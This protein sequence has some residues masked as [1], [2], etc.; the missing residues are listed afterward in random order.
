MYGTEQTS[1]WAKCQFTVTLCLQRKNLWGDQRLTTTS[2]TLCFSGVL[3]WNK[4]WKYIYIYS[5]AALLIYSD[6]KDFKTSSGFRIHMLW[7]DWTVRSLHTAAAIQAAGPPTVL[8]EPSIKARATFI[9]PQ[10]RQL[11]AARQHQTWC[12]FIRL[13]SCKADCLGEGGLQKMG[14]QATSWRR[15]FLLVIADIQVGSAKRKL[16]H[17]LHCWEIPRYEEWENWVTQPVLHITECVFI[18]FA[19]CIFF[20]LLP[21]ALV[22]IIRSS[23]INIPTNSLE[24]EP[25]SI[26]LYGSQQRGEGGVL[27]CLLSTPSG[28]LDLTRRL[29]EF[30]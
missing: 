16:F 24:A 18:S 5:T 22:I 23:R 1:N 28:R 26:C 3:H 13:P 7:I 20:P 12:W 21:I 30:D 11:T 6:H 19:N 17:L 8:V 25:P 14:F 15:K 9:L 2:F 10:G 27:C 4:T 29:D